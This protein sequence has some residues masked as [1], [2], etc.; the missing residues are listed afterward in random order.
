MFLLKIYTYCEQYSG[1]TALI[2]RK[3]FTDLKDSTMRDFERYFNVKI[4]ADKDYYLPNTSKI[5]FRHAAEIEV[6]K[7]INLGIAGIEQA[8]EFETDEQFQFIRDRLRQQNGADI[9]PLCVIANA[10]GHNWVWKYWFNNPPSEEYHGIT[11][12]TFDN[13]I[14]LPKDFIAD[15]RRME[16]EAPNHYKQ[17]VLNS[18]EETDQDDYVF[19]WVELNEAKKNIYGLREG[20]GLRISGFDVARYGEDKCADVTIQ[21]NGALNWQVAHKEQWQKKDG[22]YTIGRIQSIVNTV[23]SEF[24]IVDEDGLGG[25]MLDVIN[26]KIDD[27]NKKYKGFRNPSISYEKNKFYGNRRTEAIFKLKD[28][29]TKGWLSGLDDELCEEL[30][31]LKFVYQTDGR[32]IL[33][34]KEV[35]RAEGIKSPNLADALLMAVSLIGEINYKQVNQYSYSQ[36]QYSKED[37]ILNLAGIK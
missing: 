8:E 16:T 11:A 26:A 29:I 28:M 37:N 4:G 27:P 1:T 25:P 7:N 23:H 2:V 22:D 20:Y 13:E 36:P 17:Y 10:N 14:N 3:E 33:V 9:R 19:T 35:M 32:R 31:T 24:N 30:M 21:Q 5:M 12:T 15:L 6:L 34:S 18:F